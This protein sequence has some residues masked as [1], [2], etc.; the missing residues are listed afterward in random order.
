MIKKMERVSAIVMV[1]FV[2]SLLC[3]VAIPYGRASAPITLYVNPSQVINQGLVPNTTFNVSVCVENVPL[4]ADLVGIQFNLTWNP[5]LLQGTSMQEVVFHNITPPSDY[6]NI[7][8]LTNIVTNDSVV[9]AY[10]FENMGTAISAGYAPIVGNYT[11]ANIALKVI[12]SGECILHLA[13]SKLGDPNGKPISHNTVDG[14][15]D[16]VPPPPPA[17]LYVDP[18]SIS[19][20][21]LTAGNN[22]TID[23]DVSN[24]TGI[25]GLGFA[26]SFNATLLQVNSATGGSFIPIMPSVQINNTVGFVQFNATVP[27]G[28]SGSGI[29]ETI[30]FQVQALGQT[31]LHVYNAQLTDSVGLPLS[32]S[33]TDGY[34]ANIL[35]P[36][37]AVSPSSIINVSL[38]PTSTFF[39]NITAAEVIGLYGYQFDLSFNPNILT[40]ILV[41]VNDVSNET[42]YTPIQTVD[43]GLGYIFVNVTYYSPAVPI[44][45]D[46]ATPLVTI[47][48]RV[49]ALG[50]TNLTLTKTSLVDFSGL[51]ITCEIYNGYFQSIVVDIAALGVSASPSS[52]YHGQSINVTLIVANYGT[53]AESFIANVYFNTTLMATANITSLAPNANETITVVVNTT[54][55]KPDYYLLAYK[56]HRSNTKLTPQ[57]TMSPMA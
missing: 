11:V 56:N 49:N 51:P 27:T 47:E 1:F 13:V 14:L 2:A 28:L 16:N 24:A 22:F 53:T 17:I 21:T 40:C 42:H 34:F 45:I 8:E 36:K 19:D 38:V 29:L 35:V 26:L 7:W 43:N 30:S 48:F 44:D 20:V 31:V 52:F 33:T 6:G 57:T 50:I 3:F 54:L 5:N 46:A 12:G 41:Q 10:T 4:S 25:C 15:F 37:L 18:P 23:V 9:Y 32:S 55:I 39:V